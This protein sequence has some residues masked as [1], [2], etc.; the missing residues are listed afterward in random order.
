MSNILVSIKNIQAPRTSVKNKITMKGLV[1]FESNNIEFRGVQKPRIKKPTDALVKIVN[2]TI[3]GT[4]YDILYGITP[5]LKPRTGGIGVVEEVGNDVGKFKK[6]DHVIISSITACG[7]CVYCK[8]Q[9]YRQCKDGDGGLVLDN[10]IN[11]TQSEYLRVPY[12]DNCLYVVPKGIDFEALALLSDILPNNHEM[13]FMNGCVKP[14]DTIA[15]VGA[16]PN[17]MSVLLRV[18]P[19]FPAK[20]YMIDL[21]ANC[22]ALAKK[23]GATHTINSGEEDAVKKIK[24][25]TKVGVD[26]AIEAV[27]V[28]AT[29]GICQDIVQPSGH[30]VNIGGRGFSIDLQIQ[31][32]WIQ[33]ITITKGLIDT[34]AT[35]ILQKL[36]E[37]GKTKPEASNTLWLKLNKMIKAC[38][39]F[40]NAVKKK[41][42]KIIL[43]SKLKHIFFI[44]NL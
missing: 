17:G 32:L 18:Q 11:G 44:N 4:D 30:I 14:G 23:L 2:T 7:S 38:K 27:G 16:G 13:G 5:S 34:N 24:S 29:F 42:L 19:Y 10:L 26:V 25:E 43:T 6:G 3:S 36:V 15:I 21:D 1:Y 22:L 40:G 37:S 12:A 31:Y 39:A 35:P 33:N 28:P 9:M 8:M 41:E 20:I